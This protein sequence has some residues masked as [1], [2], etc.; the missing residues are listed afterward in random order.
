MAFQNFVNKHKGCDYST[1]YDN[2]RGG[3]I[4]CEEEGRKYYYVYVSNETFLRIHV[5]G[6]LIQDES[7]RKCDYLLLNTTEQWSKTH[8][9]NFHAIFIELKGKNIQKAREQL[10]ATIDKYDGELLGSKLYAR[11]VASEINF[12]RSAPMNP[13]EQPYKTKSSKVTCFFKC[14]SSPMTEHTGKDGNPTRK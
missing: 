8:E 7:V 12:K 5:D 3:T 14:V 4:V 13:V 10:L 6:G 11:I 2:D 1:V 9:S